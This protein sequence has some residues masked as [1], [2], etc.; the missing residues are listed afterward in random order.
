MKTSSSSVINLSFS[1]FFHAHRCRMV[2]AFVS[3]ARSIFVVFLFLASPLGG[4]S[5][6][7]LRR[8]FGF[9]F[10]IMSRV[11]HPSEKNRY[12]QMEHVFIELTRFACWIAVRIYGNLLRRSLKMVSLVPSP[13]SA[14]LDQPY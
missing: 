11:F 2:D 9:G 5:M 4:P 13:A 3:N 12:V 14:S 8:R 7:A 1:C 10:D 6:D